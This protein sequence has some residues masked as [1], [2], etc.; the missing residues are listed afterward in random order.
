MERLQSSN[1][2]AIHA[3]TQ[4]ITKSGASH[5]GTKNHCKGS[6]NPESKHFRQESAVAMFE[7]AFVE[8]K[9][10]GWRLGE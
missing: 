8:A 7:V 5:Y 6:I 10:A 1:H 2:D 9:L 3:M 4:K